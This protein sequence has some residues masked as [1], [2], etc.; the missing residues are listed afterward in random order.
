MA[1]ILE[2]YAYVVSSVKTEIMEMYGDNQFGFQPQVSTLHAHLELHDY[3]TSQLDQIE[4]KG[5]LLISFDMMKA[6]DKI[7][8]E[9]LLELFPFPLFLVISFAGSQVIL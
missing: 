3:I 2:K 7:D 8:Y 6:F 9:A 1:K 5:A 4:T